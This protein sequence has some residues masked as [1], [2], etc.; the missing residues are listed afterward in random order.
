MEC[1]QLSGSGT[2][3]RPAG[4]KQEY[5]HET[6]D[7]LRFILKQKTNRNMVKTVVDLYFVYAPNAKFPHLFRSFLSK[8]YLEISPCNEKT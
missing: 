4:L 5:T 8:I 2:R 6:F 7:R 1:S 3:R